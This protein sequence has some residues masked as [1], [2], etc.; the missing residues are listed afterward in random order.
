M[1]SKYNYSYSTLK[2]AV[3]ITN[4]EIVENPSKLMA[5]YKYMSKV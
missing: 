3:D 4:I 5:Q 2:S 1:K